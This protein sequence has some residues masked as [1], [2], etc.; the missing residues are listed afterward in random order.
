[1]SD[2]NDPFA[3]PGSI[4]GVHPFDK[5]KRNPKSHE[6]LFLKGGGGGGGAAAKKAR[7]DRERA[8]QA[9]QDQTENAQDRV[10]EFPA[11]TP[12]A[13]EQPRARTVKLINAQWDRE[14]GFFNKKAKA[15]VDAETL[16]GENAKGKV[17]F[18]LYAVDPEGK[19][20]RID[21]YLTNLRGGHAEAEF[22]LYY[23][24]NHT[25]DQAAT[26]LFTARHPESQEVESPGLKVQ[27]LKCN[28]APDP[29]PADAIG[30]CPYYMWR[31]DNFIERHQSCPRNPPEYYLGYGYKYCVRFSTETYPKLSE[32]GKKWLDNARTLLQ[33]AIE[34]ELKKNGKIEL[35]SKRFKSFAFGTHVGAYWNAGL[36]SLP[37]NDLRRIVLTPDFKE[38][39]D[40]KSRQQAY[41]IA[42]RLFEAIL[43]HPHSNPRGSVYSRLV[44]LT[45][46]QRKF[47]GLG[48]KTSMGKHPKFQS[49]GP[50]G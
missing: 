32:K 50:P 19:R 15:E 18:T 33:Q 37:L 27:A 31:N 35:D 8:D 12:P 41:D 20:E 2:R 7:E 25:K 13:R 46:Y 26:Y 6:D 45:P 11:E 38:W 42:G 30:K 16:E 23:A 10:M 17:E 29:A 49:T 14:Q 3:W 34:Q 4:P 44:S 1:M 40:P 21:G 22:T 48:K 39:E 24:R 47:R 28:D 9:K 43:P 36:S 5:G